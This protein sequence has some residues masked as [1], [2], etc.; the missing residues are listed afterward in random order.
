MAT[1]REGKKT[2][3]LVVDVQV[4]LTRSFEIR[5]QS[6]YNLIGFV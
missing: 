1:I 2:A 6:I 5:I 3:L 4:V